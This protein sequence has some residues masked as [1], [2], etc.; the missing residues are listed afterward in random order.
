MPENIIRT[1]ELRTGVR[2]GGLEGLLWH[3]QW[4]TRAHDFVHPLCFH[5]TPTLDGKVH[6]LCLLV[7]TFTLSVPRI[8]PSTQWVLHKVIEHRGVSEG[9]IWT[10]STPLA[11]RWDARVSHIAPL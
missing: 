7:F 4:F 10:N 11:F 6:G 1:T 5:V 9:I 3:V 8:V 2:D